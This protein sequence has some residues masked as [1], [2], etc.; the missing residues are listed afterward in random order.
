M[1]K[2]IKKIN[3]RTITLTIL[4]VLILVV[5]A[6][7]I[8]KFS[9][10]YLAPTVSDDVEGS[11]EVTASG[12][13]IIFTKGNTLSLSANSDNFKT[14]GSNLTATTNPKVKL[15]ASSKT[16]S[17]SS[18]YFAGVIIKNN[19]Y[20]YTT[21]DKKPEVILTV[22][23]ENGNIVETSADNL[24]FVT[25]NDNLKGFDITGVNGAFN[26][27]TD[28]V[29][30]TAS[31]KSEV[32]HTW[33]FTLTFVNLGTDQSNNENSTLNIDVVLQKDKL[34]TS[35]A[36]F[37][38][39]GDNLNDCIVSFYNNLETATNMYFHDLS[40]TNGAEDNSYRFAGANPNNYVCFGSDD[41]TC[42]TENLYRIIGLIDGKVKLIL[43]D[44]A[45]IEMLGTDGG[46]CNDY[47]SFYKA[48]SMYKG[49]GDISKIGVYYW[50]S[51]GKNIWSTSITNI[52]NLNTN[53]LT[54]LDGK[55]AKWQSMIDNTTWYVGGM[56]ST[57]GYWNSNAKKAYNY[58]VGANKDAATTVTSKI[59][60]MYVSDYYYGAVL[61][62]WILPGWT[63][64]AYDYRKAYNDNWM[65]I[66]LRDPTI[67]R[68]T[69]GS[70]GLYAVDVDGHIGWFDVDGGGFV[71]RPTF[72]LVSS[73][74]YIGGSGTSE[75]P[76]RIS[77]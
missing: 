73:I 61:D 72:N 5:I 77:L 54:Y 71:L 27:V 13:T 9:Y 17:A 4:F 76:I 58:E 69:F 66:G 51:T 74:K 10:S 56:T 34:L 19:T 64:S 59:G 36:D 18:K 15:M 45:T 60:L 6:L 23:D 25:V 33:T 38:A 48:A 3:A 1:D 31:N 44:G 26:I 55:N 37:C 24:T 40:L 47:K 70:D 52:T 28:H 50:N 30:A 32:I 68:N 57:N 41:T 49:S 75:N 53:Y 65:C 12:D 43:A 16:E 35:I 21:T 14:G 63:T 2:N 22:K 11:G 62:Y 7:L 67:S 8:G 39:N 46:Y 29:I 20:T 42:P